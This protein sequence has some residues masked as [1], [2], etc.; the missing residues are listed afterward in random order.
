MRVKPAQIRL[1][2]SS[3]CQL[4]CPS[5]PTTRGDVHGG[6]V[7]AGTLRFADFK[8]LVDENP[9]VRRI[10]LSNWGEIFLNPD[11]LEIIRHGHEKGVALAASNGANLNHVKDE[12]LEGLVKHRFQAITCSIDGASQE[13]YARYRVRGDFERVLA[14]VRRI[15]EFKRLFGSDLPALVWQFIVFG[16]NEHELPKARA[17]ARELGMEF[18]PKLTW[19]DSFSPVR[20]A[21]FVRRETGL[22]AVSREEFREREGR[23]YMPICSQ[24]WDLPQINYDGKV[25]GCCANFWG[26][27]GNAFQEGLLNSLNN[28]RMRHARLMLRGK[29]QERPDVPCTTCSYYLRMKASGR[30]LSRPRRGTQLARRVVRGVI[31]RLRAAAAFKR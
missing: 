9:W 2:A 21:E 10:E 7:G 5:C 23:E 14:N 6:S 20:D 22:A 29:A 11:L 25:L 12:V 13:T 8:R 24:L 3:Q 16:H 30:W 31:R 18:R 19:D 26:D 27:F 17:L 1:E 15:N 4:R 28:D